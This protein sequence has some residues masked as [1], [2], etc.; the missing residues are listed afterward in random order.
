MYGRSTD[1]PQLGKIATLKEKTPARCRRY[2]F[3]AMRALLTAL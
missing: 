2:R 3:L 1:A